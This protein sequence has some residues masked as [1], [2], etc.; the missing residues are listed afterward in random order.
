MSALDHD[1]LLPREIHQSLLLRLE[2]F[3]KQVR[4]R[5]LTEGLARWV[6]SSVLLAAL[7]FVLDRTFRLSSP[8]RLSMLIAVLFG[9]G[10]IAWQQLISPL[11]L[12]FD[13][14]TLAAAMDRAGSDESSA[15]TASIG[16]VL[17]LPAM[18]SQTGSSSSAMVC[19]AVVDCHRTI[20]GVDFGSRLD[21]RRRNISFA[22]ILVSLLLPVVCATAAPAV[23]RLWAARAIFGSNEPWPQKTYLQVAGLED[24]V[25]AVPRGEPFVLRV[26][27]RPGSVPPETVSLR[28]REG[29][30]S[31][32]TAGLTSFGPND[33]RYEFP[34]VDSAVEAEVWGGDDVFGPFTIRVAERPKIIDMKLIA[35]HPTEAKP[36]TYSFSGS[37]ADLSFL[38]RTHMQL[39]F[40]ANTPIAEARLKSSTTQPATG[41]LKQIDDRDFSVRWDQA[42]AVQLEIE[43]TSRD[44]QLA[45]V[46]TTVS[47][48]LKVDQPPRVTMGFTGVRQRVTARA[49]IPLTIEARDD[50]GIAKAGLALKTETPD[51]ANP[52]Q[53]KADNSEMPLFGPASPATELQLEKAESLE[54]EPMKLT[55]GSLLTVNATATDACY[56]GEQ[57][58]RSRQVTFRI[59]PPE[60]LFR[61]ILLRQQA[62]RAKFRK[63]TDEATA[64]HEKLM[65]LGSPDDVL[66]V[67]RR[68]RAVQREVSHITTTLADS[69]TEMRLNALATDEAYELMDKNVLMP[70]KQLNEELLNPQKDAL[71]AMKADDSKA[72]ADA[73]DRQ[74]KIV[75]RMESILKQMSQWDSFVDVLNQLNEIIKMQDQAK[76]STGELKK[77]QTEGIFEK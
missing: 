2:D 68:Q 42:S 30:G 62:E 31:R 45:S 58:G 27:A 64:V 70:L 35:Q 74:D 43:L 17:E 55:V 36:Q 73:A 49:K 44:A 46:P 25:I 4:L 39:L 5:L 24:N 56:L 50:Y 51:P 33:F 53:L 16:T 40:S 22:V 71:D 48:G 59:V 34:T 14:L 19:R 61:E 69:L 77:Q 75:A 72:L 3:R 76:Q 26:N 7:T 57:T 8:A 52:A 18:L 47:I 20:S 15:L 54:L 41:D 21:D 29:G 11:L 28:Y 12:K 65:T 23:F 63:Q 9:L 32:V 1:I 13:P 6:A 37:D 38:A 10:I 60:E 66:Q 67:G